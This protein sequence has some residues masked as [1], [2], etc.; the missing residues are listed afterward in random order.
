[1]DA[2]KYVLNIRFELPT[3]LPP[4]EYTIDRGATYDCGGLKFDRSPQIPF[5][6][7]KS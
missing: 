3:W 2:G 7:V 5:S 6:I 4:G 1:L